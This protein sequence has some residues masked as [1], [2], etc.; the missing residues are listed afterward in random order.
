MAKLSKFAISTTA[1]KEGVE[2]DLGDG[3][4]VRVAKANNEKYQAYLKQV[5]KPYERQVR[6]GSLD[7]KIFAKLYNEAVAETIL[8][9]WK[10]LEDDNGA[11]IPY[12]K[13]KA[14]EILTNPE[15]EEFKALVV[16]LANEQAVFSKEAVEATKSSA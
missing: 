13:E 1:A 6:N 15:Y 14:I 12:T 16:D 8:L 4:I 9:G 3:L 10:G 2:V 11:E 7:E 5:L